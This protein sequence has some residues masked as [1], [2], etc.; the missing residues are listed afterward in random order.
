MLSFGASAPVFW[1][2]FLFVVGPV[3]A[4]EENN[5]SFQKP[6]DIRIQA[7]AF[8]RASPAEITAVLNSAASEIW[9]YCTR[10]QIA[11]IDVY[12]RPDHPQTDFKRKAS[13]RI[14]IGLS[15]HDTHWAQYSF[16]FAHEFCHALVNFSNN[17]NQLVRYP[18]HANLWLEESFCETASLFSLRAMGRSWQV[19]PPYPAWRTYAPW[20]NDYAA[21]RFVLPEHQLPAETPFLVWFRQKEPAL[22]QNPDMR[23]TNTIIALQ[24]LPI[25]E[26]EPHDWQA[27]AYLDR[28]LH[29]LNESLEQRFFTWRSECPADLRPFVSRLATIF[30][31][32][33]QQRRQSTSASSVTI[34]GTGSRLRR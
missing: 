32:T 7:N 12:Y 22:R 34:Q 20:L 2:L 24:F 23:D 33:L 19:D 17:P 30:G 29:N 15:A 8:G 21:K 10:T 6:L 28:G 3:G 11:G 31:L 14:A 9:R 4:V 26:A 13:G 5:I 1:L 18:R 27:V 25:F 16:Q